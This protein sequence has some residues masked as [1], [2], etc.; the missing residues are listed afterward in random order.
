MAIKTYSWVNADGLGV[1]FGPREG[2][3]GNGGEYKSYGPNR[4][5]AVVINL[6][7]LTSTAQYLDQN[8]ELPKGA[9]IEQVTIETL[10][11]ATSGGSAT[12]NVGLKS[13]DQSTTLSDTAIVNAAALST[14]TAVGT[15]L[16]LTAG[17]TAVGSSVGTKLAI[18]ELIT[19]KWGTAAFT[20]GKIEVRIL[21]NF[22][23]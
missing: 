12:L 16:T 5:L 15:K 2:V 21:Y 9:F 20:A 23:A 4:E 6:T 13:S 3:A 7:D 18:N 17:S 8:F 11:A 22:V 19:A 1:Y 14:F 10:V